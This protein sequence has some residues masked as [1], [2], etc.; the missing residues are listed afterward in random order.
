MQAGAGVEHQ[1]AGGQLHLLQAVGVLDHQFAA[2][3]VLRV[4]EEEG[5]GQVGTDPL[6][7]AMDVAHGVVDVEVERAPAGIAVEQRR[8]DLE[9]Q[10][11]GHEQGMVPQA[12]QHGFADLP[13]QR[14]VLRQLQVVLGLGRL[15]AGGRLAVGPFRLLQGCADPGDFL[16]GEDGGNMQQHGAVHEGEMIANDID[17]HWTC[18]TARNCRRARWEKM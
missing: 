16:G 14:V 1:I 18:K 10:G 11:G 4:A 8:E 9:R 15:V 13:G 3:I 7:A 17:L 2:V 6:A 12:L 5:R